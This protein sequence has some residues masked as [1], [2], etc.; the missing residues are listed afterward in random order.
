MLYIIVYCGIINVKVVDIMF[1]KQ[2]KSH[3]G[4]LL[5]YTIGYRENGK[6]KHKNIETIG[7]LDELKKQFEDPISHFKQIAKQ[8]TNDEINELI[9]KNLN[10]KF[11]NLDD[12]PKNLGYS[13]LKKIYNEL[14]LNTFFNNKQKNFKM[15]Y[16]LNDI[17]ELLIYSMILYPGSKLDNYNNKDIFFDKFDFSLKDMY[18]SLDYFQSMQDEIQTLIWNKTK[19]SYNRDTSSVYYDCT[20]Y[21]F[22][23]SYNDEDLIDEFGNVLEKGYRKKG[24]SK[25]HR[26]DPIIQMG[27]LMDKT[28]IP[29][30]YNLFPGNESEKTTLRPT[31]KKT[32]KH[33]NLDR[34]ITVADRGLNTS[35]NTLFIAGK[36]DDEHTNHDGYV[37]GQSVLGSDKEF[38]DYVLNQDDYL[39]DEIIDEDNNKITFKHKSRIFAKTVQIKR[40]G[41]R[42]NKSTI[43]QKQMVYYSDKYAKRQKKER[44]L[45]IAKATDLINN[46]SKYT[47]ATSYGASKYINNIDYNKQTGEVIAKDL[48]L[49][50]DKIKEEEKFDGYYSIVTSE[51]K[52]SDKEL[53]DV[54]K[55]LWK[56]EESF[57][58]TKSNLESRPVYV[59]TKEHI[60]AHF[61]T[62][63]VSLVIL[64]LLEQKISRKYSTEK[65]INSL[66]NWNCSKLEHDIYLNSNYSTEIND[67]LNKFNHDFSNKY[68]N[69][70][71]IKHLLK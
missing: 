5:T 58:I 67:I 37:F 66:K 48:S 17:F 9:I 62:C 20:N 59:W 33:Y 36:N 14:D 22:E 10:S 29:L 19:D 55:G 70:K 18:R 46:P 27:L 12:K 31:L 32:K 54:Y 50:L 3:K 13:I 69:F 39:F 25:E 43:Y 49:K 28:G 42:T 24:P 65:I 60:E 68:I 64:R 4:I 45:V 47:L 8:R 41:K 11:L 7:Y 71:K 30:S 51:L 52:M 1:V 15:D 2:N 63:F 44:D 21:Y 57:K 34:V 56:I 53:R 61:L 38:K 26:K 6:V 35:D 16:K 40:D 23:I